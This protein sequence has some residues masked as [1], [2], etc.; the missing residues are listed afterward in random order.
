MFKKEV[1]DDVILTDCLLWAVFLYLLL[2][3]PYIV[4]I[5]VIL[6]LGIYFRDLMYRCLLDSANV[7]LLIFATMD[8]THPFMYSMI[9]IYAML[10]A[11]AN[12]LEI[13]KS[14][15]NHYNITFFVIMSG[16]A[17]WVYSNDSL[18]TLMI[19][20]TTFST[21]MGI[22]LL[23][24]LLK[25]YVSR[26]KREQES[27]EK[28]NLILERTI[29]KLII[30]DRGYTLRELVLLS[31]MDFPCTDELMTNPQK[32]FKQLIILSSFSNKYVHMFDKRFRLNLD[33]L[34]LSAY[35][36]TILHS[37]GSVVNGYLEVE[38]YC[39]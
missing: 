18:L 16:Y 6:L 8:K 39:Q 9:P 10:F 19:L 5:A 25:F 4:P 35:D 31:G 1:W 34:N 7:A 36:K 14:W 37:I 23:N 21:I 32:T 30:K 12:N 17:F 26:I 28:L 3:I 2:G 33:T 11:I 24:P 20:G 29:Q 15:L 38:I 27:L 22:H 13:K